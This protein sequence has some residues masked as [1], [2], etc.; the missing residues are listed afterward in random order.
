MQLTYNPNKSLSKIKTVT[1]LFVNWESTIKQF[2]NNL[3][4]IDI[5]ASNLL[6]SFWYEEFTEKGFI[7]AYKDMALNRI[8]A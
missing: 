3:C 1:N 7:E 6:D 2:K 5:D 8:L 4:R